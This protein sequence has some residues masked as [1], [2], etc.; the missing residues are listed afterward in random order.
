MEPLTKGAIQIDNQTTENVS[1]S[2]NPNVFEM[3]NQI[4]IGSEFFV[5]QIHTRIQTS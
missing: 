2:E 1:K 3:R 5:R 4:P